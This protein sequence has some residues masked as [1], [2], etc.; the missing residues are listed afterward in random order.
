[1]ITKRLEHP[2]LI[3]PDSPLHPRNNTPLPKTHEQKR[4]IKRRP[5]EQ[6]ISTDWGLTT[7]QIAKRL[8]ISPSAVRQYMHRHEVPYKLIKNP[9]IGPSI[10]FWEKSKVLPLINSYP[11]TQ[12]KMPE[13]YI[14]GKE[15]CMLLNVSNTSLTRICS[16]HKINSKLIKFA[17]KDAW[18]MH[19]IYKRDHILKV[20]KMYQNSGFYAHPN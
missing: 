3:F 13:G 18:R 15:A 12:N 17:K 7:H 11:K 4:I 10:L 1:M 19:R 6:G 5:I 2:G 8:G 14:T 16:R 9:L 20:L